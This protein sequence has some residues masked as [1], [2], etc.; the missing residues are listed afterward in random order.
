MKNTYAEYKVMVL[1]S[2]YY[3]KTYYVGIFGIEYIVE[4]TSQVYLSLLPNTVANH[5]MELRHIRGCLEPT[6]V[7]TERNIR[8]IHH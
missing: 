4:V 5:A 2:G 3:L 6:E 7:I 8:A 1:N